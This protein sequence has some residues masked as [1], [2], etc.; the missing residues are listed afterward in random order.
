M[1]SKAVDVDTYMAGVPGDRKG[2]LETL[3]ALCRKTHPRHDEVIEYG[4]PSYRR[5]GK[6][7]LAFASQKQYIALYVMHPGLVD[8]YREQFPKAKIGKGCIRFTKPEHIDFQL[9]GQLLKEASRL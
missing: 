4:M 1:I 6:V 2:A 3:R 7:E 5:G 9:I 8:R